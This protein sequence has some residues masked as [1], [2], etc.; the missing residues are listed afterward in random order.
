MDSVSCVAALFSISSL[1]D[2]F[3]VQDHKRAFEFDAGG[4]TGGMGAI[5]PAPDVSSSLLCQIETEVL[6]VRGFL[7]S[8]C[9]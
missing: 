8:Y 3:H 9:D 4:N 7:R 5:A 2:P 6:Q 1:C